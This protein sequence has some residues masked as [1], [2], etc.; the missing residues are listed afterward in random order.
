[1]EMSFCTIWDANATREFLDSRGLTDREQGDIGP[2]YGFQWRH[3]GAKY[4]NMHADYTGQGIDQLREVIH[5]L[6]TN[7]YDRRIIMTAWNPAGK[8]LGMQLCVCIGV[9][10]Y[11]Q[12][13]MNTYY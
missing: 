5:K 13:S 11:T 3:F 7:P 8:G 6:R 4:T 2:V 10:V 1:M 9:G 12:L